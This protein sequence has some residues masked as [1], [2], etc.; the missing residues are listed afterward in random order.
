MT[1]PGNS[2]SKIPN[3]NFEPIKNYINLNLKRPDTDQRSMS[4]QE[5]WERD[6]T[7]NAGHYEMSIS[8]LITP[9]APPIALDG[10]Y[11]FLCI[12]VKNIIH[13]FNPTQCPHLFNAWICRG[14]DGINPNNSYNKKKV[15]SSWLPISATA[16]LFMTLHRSLFLIICELPSFHCLL[17]GF[18]FLK[19]IATQC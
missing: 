3:L 7:G 10:S 17:H 2:R 9:L 4:T 5:H 15:L 13:L 14:E 12:Y 18:L 16:T 1:N 19:L 11:Q 8:L 6:A